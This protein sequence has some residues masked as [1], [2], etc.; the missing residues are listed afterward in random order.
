MFITATTEQS[1]LIKAGLFSLCLSGCALFVSTG[2]KSNP[3]II[4]AGVLYSA[5]AIVIASV[6]EKRK[7]EEEAIS[8][9]TS[10]VQDKPVKQPIIKDFVNYWIAKEK[11]LIIV[12]GTGDG[13]STLVKGLVHKLNEWEITAYDIDFARGDYPSAVNVFCDYDT[14]SSDMAAS[15]AK[16]AKRI[17]LRQVNGAEII[18]NENF[19]LTIAEELSALVKVIGEVQKPWISE[20]AKR[21]RKCRMFVMACVQNDTI[22]NTGFEGDSASVS[23]CFVKVLLGKFARERAEKLKDNELLQWLSEVPKGRFL[24]D[25]IP[26][27]WIIELPDKDAETVIALASDGKSVQDIILSVWGVKVSR[28]ASY[29]TLKTRVSKILKQ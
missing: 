26:C 7:E 20:I 4:T 1:R 22:A 24:V 9:R 29:T 15:S 10:A 18:G 21:G 8:V 17:K 14:I 6:R 28:H 16:L 2:Q 11:H 23:S 19:V 5:S 27:E 13:K 3:H 12:G 25:D